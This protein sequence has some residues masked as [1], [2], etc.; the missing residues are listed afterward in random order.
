AHRDHKAINRRLA[1]GQ[2]LANP[3]EVLE[4]LRRERGLGLGGG[5]HGLAGLEELVLQTGLRIEPLSLVILVLVLIAVLF[6]IFS[7][8]LGF[9]IMAFAL[10]VTVALGGVYLV[11]QRLRGKR[12]ARF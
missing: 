12:I 9:N 4:T 8:G 10:A 5:A 1:L 11:L 7:Y 2:Q 6:L 3:T